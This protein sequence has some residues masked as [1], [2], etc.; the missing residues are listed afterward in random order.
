MTTARGGSINSI[1]RIAGEGADSIYKI[2]SSEPL[3][4]VT[5]GKLFASYSPATVMKIPWRAYPTYQHE[6]T[7]RLPFELAHGLYSSMRSR[8]PRVQSR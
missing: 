4:G 1:G 2:F 8:M 7:F 6:Q 3:D 5:L